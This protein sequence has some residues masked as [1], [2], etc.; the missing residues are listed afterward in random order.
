MKIAERIKQ[1]N[2]LWYAML[3][4]LCLLSVLL[5]LNTWSSRKNLQQQR[6]GLLKEVAAAHA[7]YLEN[8][9]NYSFGMAQN[10]ANGLVDLIASG[11]NR[12]P[13]ADE[14]AQQGLRFNPKLLGLSSYW[15]P[16]AFDGQDQDYAGVPPYDASGRLFTWW[17]R[18]RGEITAETYTLHTV[19]EPEKVYPWYYIPKRTLKRFVTEPYVDSIGGQQLWLMSLVVPIVREGKFLGVVGA[20]YPLADF[21]QILSRQTAFNRQAK[22]WLISSGGIYASHPNP[23]W[24]G[25]K[26]PEITDKVRQAMA[27]GTVLVQPSANGEQLSVFYPI[28]FPDVKE[29]WV[30]HMAVPVAA[31]EQSSPFG[32][33]QP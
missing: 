1:H 30:L 21:Q 26:A 4:A 16:N 13:L 12:R 20:D 11:R 22:L 24:L 10:L 2:V 25:K 29:K 27:E 32:W 8:E 14:L 19:P 17:H 7:F 28:R 3:L 5:L 18:L 33:Q 15:E 6:Y 31:L 23:A 9:I